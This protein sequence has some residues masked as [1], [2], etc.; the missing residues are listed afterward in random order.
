MPLSLR[1]PRVPGRLFG[2]DGEMGLLML[3]ILAEINKP[4]GG[5]GG[6]GRC[7]PP[8]FA[9]G[10]GTRHSHEAAARAGGGAGAQVQPLP[11]QGAIKTQLGGG[12]RR[13]GEGSRLPPLRRDTSR[14]RPG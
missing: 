2:G 7:S 12:G 9:R 1:H 14:C 13:D 8:T 6:G 3:L 4:A 11:R 5:G 10:G